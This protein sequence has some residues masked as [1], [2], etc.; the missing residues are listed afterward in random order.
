MNVEK[1]RGREVRGWYYKEGWLSAFIGIVSKFEI[2][3][4]NSLVLT[5]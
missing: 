1:D 3:P 2:F 4:R 5:T